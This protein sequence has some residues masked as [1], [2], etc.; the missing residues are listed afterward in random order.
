MAIAIIHI[1]QATMAAIALLMVTIPIITLAI[2]VLHGITI[3]MILV[4]PGTTDLQGLQVRN[5]E[6][7]Y[8]ILLMIHSF[9]ALH[10]E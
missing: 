8:L 10:K 4:I 3:D 2:T 9:V 5:I 6:D 1:T 7:N